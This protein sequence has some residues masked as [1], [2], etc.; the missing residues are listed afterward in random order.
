M[1]FKSCLVIGWREASYAILYLSYTHYKVDF[2]SKGVSY[3]GVRLYFCQ[4]FLIK[5]Q[6]I[7]ILIPRIFIL[8]LTTIYVFIIAATFYSVENEKEREV[9]KFI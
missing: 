9:N 8:V 5:F 7:K 2:N 1:L 4:S 3:I 6:L